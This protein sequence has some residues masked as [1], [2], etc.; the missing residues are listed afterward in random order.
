MTNDTTKL[1]N[2]RE[3]RD[4]VLDELAGVTAASL[5]CAMPNGVAQLQSLLKKGEPILAAQAE[6]VE[7]NRLCQEEARAFVLSTGIPLT[8]YGSATMM[9][10]QAVAY[11][12]RRGRKLSPDSQKNY[13]ELRAKVTAAEKRLRESA[14]KVEALNAEIR[15]IHQELLRKAERA[16]V[17]LEAADSDEIA[18]RLSPWV[19]PAEGKQVASATPLFHARRSEMHHVKAFGKPER[20]IDFIEKYLVQKVQA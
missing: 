3:W 16:L 2:L 10:D 6:A 14:P 11:L 19:P 13:A 7:A 17:K 1:K 12:E 4:P 9:L 20:L 8:P 5:L 18:R 15:P